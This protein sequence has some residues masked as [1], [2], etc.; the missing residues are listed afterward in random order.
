M[1]P[2]EVVNPGMH[3]E[4]GMNVRDE[5]GDKGVVVKVLTDRNS[6]LV[7]YEDGREVEKHYLFHD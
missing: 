5:H 2:N 1:E 6:A 7:Q 4:P 3:L